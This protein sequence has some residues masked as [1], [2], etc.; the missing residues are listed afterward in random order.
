MPIVRSILFLLLL[1]QVTKLVFRLYGHELDLQLV[2]IE[3][4]LYIDEVVFNYGNPFLPSGM[5][6]TGVVSLI[7]SYGSASVALAGVL[8]GLASIDETDTVFSVSPYVLLAAGIQGNTFDRLI[9]GNVSDWITFTRPTS[10]YLGILNF[11]DI[12]L[13]TGLLI[14]PFTMHGLRY[15]VPVGAMCLFG[16]FWPLRNM[17]LN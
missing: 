4:Y 5:E 13:W 8:F 9:Y 6:E 3:G 7:I 2:L 11:A 15:Q 12:W 16:V 14:L 17:L 1:D 10:D